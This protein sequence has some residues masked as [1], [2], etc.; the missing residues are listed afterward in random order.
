MQLFRETQDFF[1]P[2][3]NET[4]EEL[5]TRPPLIREETPIDVVNA[6]FINGAMRMLEKAGA[7]FKIQDKYGKLYGT[8]VVAEVKKPRKKR[9]ARYK[10]GELINFYM[11]F[12]EKDTPVGGQFYIPTGN[13]PAE[14]VRS[15]LCSTLSGLWGL[16]SYTT[17]IDK[18]LVLVTR[19][20]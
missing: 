7:S 10:R 17:T 11:P 20:S 9:I 4:R 19:L 6:Q 13:Y 18:D 2:Y 1:M 3:R 12:L 14:H 8:L 5:T 15:A 16:K